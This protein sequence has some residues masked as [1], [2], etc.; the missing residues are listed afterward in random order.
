M[1]A[2]YQLK[3]VYT[4]LAW[5]VH[6][7]KSISESQERPHMATI[8][9]QQ[10]DWTFVCLWGFNTDITIL[11]IKLRKWSFYKNINLPKSR[12]QIWAE[13]SGV[14]IPARARDFS[15]L[16]LVSQLR[17]CSAGRLPLPPPPPKIFTERTVTLSVTLS[18]EV[19]FKFRIV[20]KV[21]D[22][23]HAATWRLAGTKCKGQCSRNATASEG[24]LK[25]GTPL[26]I[27]FQRHY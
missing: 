14:R 17:T 10:Q 12:T 20:F 25:K 16:H 21:G 3:F 22:T 23:A 8:P 6:D 11:A 13:Q 5:N 15:L 2:T 9:A 1:P 19:W 7:G 4:A 27:H 18:I 24:L 26:S